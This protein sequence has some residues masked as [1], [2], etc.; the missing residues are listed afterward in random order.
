MNSKI[1]KLCYIPIGLIH[2]PYKEST[3]TPIQ[4]IYSDA[5]CEVEVFNEYA[6]GLKDL[7][8]FSHIILIYNTHLIN[9]KTKMLVTPFLDNE[10]RGVFACRA[11]KRPNNIAMS[12]VKLIKVNANSIIVKGADIIDGS[13]LI[14]IKPYVKLFDCF[15]DANNGWVGN[16]SD[17]KMHNKDD[18]RFID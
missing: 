8:L 2:S 5:E 17:I 7:E 18:G 6:P 3:G 12:I 13:P 16:T 9:G 10:E 15:P 11:P 4:S 1:N 14:D